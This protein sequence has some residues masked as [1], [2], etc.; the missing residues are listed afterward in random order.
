MMCL[1]VEG[2]LQELAKGLGLFYAPVSL[3]LHKLC[4]HPPFFPLCGVQHHQRR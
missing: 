2:K 4:P 1:R 3:R